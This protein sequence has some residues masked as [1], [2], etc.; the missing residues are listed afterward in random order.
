MLA[1]LKAGT[2]TYQDIFAERQQDWRTQFREAAEAA[3]F[4]K[5]LA[6]EFSVDGAEVSVEEIA[7]KL[8]SGI[9]AAGPE[10]PPKEE[11]ITAANA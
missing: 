5:K 7:D 4:L 8:D 6:K 11:P 9:A 3:A 1:E 2:M 10:K